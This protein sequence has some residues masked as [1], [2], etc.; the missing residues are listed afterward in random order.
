MK[1]RTVMIVASAMAIFGCGNDPPRNP[2]SITTAPPSNNRNNT[3]GDAG[4]MGDGGTTEDMMAPEDMAEPDPD[5]GG[6]ED[7]GSDMS[8][9]CVPET[10]AEMCGRYNFECGPLQDLDNCGEMRTIDSCGDELT[11]CLED[12]SCGG[13]GIPGQCGCAP[14]T[15]EDLGV[16]CGMVDDTCGGALNCDLFCVDQISA[17]DAH[18]CAIGS[19]KMKCWGNGSDGA[20]GTGGSSTEKNPVDVQGLT[21]TVTQAAAGGHHT[22]VVDS[23]QRVLCWGKNDRSQLGIGTTVDSDLPGT[24]A[25]FADADRVEAGNEHTCALSADKLECWGS[26]EFGQIGDPSFNINANVGVPSVP[27]DLD[28]GVLDF[29]VG[30]NHTCVIVDDAAA[31]LTRALKCWGRNHF[32]QVRPLPIVGQLQDANSSA[33][34]DYWAYLPTPG[35]DLSSL[36]NQPTTI[37]D[38]NGQPW[39]GVKEVATGDKHTCIIDSSDQVWCWGFMPGFDPETS[40]PRPDDKEPKECS[41]FPRPGGIIVARFNNSGTSVSSIEGMWVANTPTQVPT[42]K[43][44]VELAGGDDH[45]CMRVSDPDANAGNIY[46]WGNS[47]F[48]QLGDGTNN[49]WTDPRLV[50]TDTDGDFVLSTQIE[51]GGRHSCAL[52]DNSNINCWGSNAKSQ[53]GNSDLMR[54]ESYRPFDVRLEVQLMP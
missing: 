41:V 29:S 39:T 15:C 44:P 22:C 28:S 19:G 18:N 40:C 24:P 38:A 16:L 54:D 2:N 31:G 49:N 6:D 20:L 52:V 45:H 53:I 3:G 26:N 34:F 50:I 12:Q 9:M 46:C 47:A 21:A 48:G 51:L 43:T 7:M 36:I 25:I 33:M 10:D 27:T 5:T 35:W 23:S 42:D 17:G 37:N 30:T 13:G 1:L 32:A 4:D 14:S 11:V 8:D